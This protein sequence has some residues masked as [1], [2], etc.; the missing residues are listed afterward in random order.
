MRRDQ[1]RPSALLTRARGGRA[2]FV[3]NSYGV[4]GYPPSQ[5][6][7]SY[8]NRLAQNHPLPCGM[9]S[10]SLLEAANRTDTLRCRTRG[11]PYS[12][13]G[14]VCATARAAARVLGFFDSTNVIG[15]GGI[16]RDQHAHRQALF[17]TWV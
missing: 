17:A 11:A 16:V 14:D 15:C 7:D 5:L 3:K 6:S 13:M 12:L 8:P 10:Y 1:Y 9:N 2:G 4:M